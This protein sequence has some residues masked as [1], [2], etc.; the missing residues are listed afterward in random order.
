MKRFDEKQKCGG[1]EYVCGESQL[2]PVFTEMD[3]TFSNPFMGYG[4]VGFN[5]GLRGRSV[6][7]TMGAWMI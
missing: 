2:Q 7:G 5:T 1:T 6:C 4:G 3:W